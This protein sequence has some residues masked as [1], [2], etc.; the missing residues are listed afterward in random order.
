MA[1]LLLFT[2]NHPFAFTGGE[3]MFVTPE[4]PALA[5]AFDRVTVV[6]LYARGEQLPLP[7]G[8]ALDTGLAQTWWRWRIWHLLLAPTWPGFW[9]E[10]GRG[11]RHGGWIGAAR[12]WRWAAVANATWRWLRTRTASHTMLLYSYW[13]GGQTLAAVRWASARADRLVVTR[14]HGYDLYAEA[15]EPPFQPWTALYSRLDRVLAISR[16]GAR[17]LQDLGVSASRVQL[18]RLGV[19]ATTRARASSDGVWR[20]VSCS[21]LNATKR[22]DRIAA[23]LARLARRRPQQRVAWTHFGAGSALP[24]LH[25]VLVDAPANLSVTLAG[26]VPNQVVLAHYAAEPVD[27]FILLSRSEGLPVSI[28]EA[29]AAGIPVLACDVGGVGEAIDRS[30]DNGVLVPVDVGDEVITDVLEQLLSEG[31]RDKLARREAAWRRWA[32]D[33][34]AAR[35]H[36][37]LADALRELVERPR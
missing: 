36:A 2:S 18:A 3:T 24:T 8:V 20:V 32:Q 7:P 31:E 37:Q 10:F 12:V 9:P 4:L 15:F 29:L 22:V 30:G 17:Y 25:A 34:D 21:N 5:A 6:P 28:Q 23:L 11:W 26:S 19:G 16:H 35:N 33:F 13:R 1:E 14:V 27:V